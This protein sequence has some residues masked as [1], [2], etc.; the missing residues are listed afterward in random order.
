MKARVSSPVNAAVCE[1]ALA[2]PAP[3][4]RV[5]TWWTV[6]DGARRETANH[7]CAGHVAVLSNAVRS[8][9]VARYGHTPV[10]IIRFSKAAEQDAR[11]AGRSP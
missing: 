4:T 6:N 8:G 3:P 7:I 11:K 1:A 5:V 2:C 10:V 9:N